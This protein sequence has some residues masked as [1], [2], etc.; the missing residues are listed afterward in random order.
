MV[1]LE[2]RNTVFLVIKRWNET[3]GG[4]LETVC[5][6]RDMNFANAFFTN[7]GFPRARRRMFF[8]NIFKGKGIH[9]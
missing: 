9:S 7:C 4:D 2:A 3:G 5:G 1:T 6:S 8:Y